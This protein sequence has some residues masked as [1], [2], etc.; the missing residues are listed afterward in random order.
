MHENLRLRRS[1]PNQLNRMPQK[2]NNDRH[3]QRLH[4]CRSVT[5]AVDKPALARLINKAKQDSKTRT[6]SEKHP[7]PKRHAK[8]RKAETTRGEIL[9]AAAQLFAEKGYSECNLR[10]LA[11]RVGM[12]AGSFYYHFRSK[13]QILDELLSASIF[14]VSDAVTRAVADLGSTMPVR[15]RIAAAMRAHITAFLSGDNNSASF[16]RVWEHLPP[17]FKRRKH[18]KRRAYA[19]IWHDLIAEGMREGEIRNDMDIGLIVPFVIGTM[20]RSIEWYRPGRM[21]IDDVCNLIIAT[22]LDGGLGRQG[23]GDAKAKCPG[24]LVSR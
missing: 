3:S 10:E 23:Q 4:L 8:L 5:A 15:D 12:K 16:M 17:T 24:A 19:Q 11:D 22:C 21:S 20:S 18:E 9:A 7:A 6:M 13:E 14:M 1:G 2:R